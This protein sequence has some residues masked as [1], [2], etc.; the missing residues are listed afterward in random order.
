MLIAQG[1][2][3]LVQPQRSWSSGSQASKGMPRTEVGGGWEVIREAAHQHLSRCPPGSTLRARG[4]A[5]EG[6]T[7]G[8]IL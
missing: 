4:E 2:A 8:R 5:K 7:T 1:L 3:G 6:G